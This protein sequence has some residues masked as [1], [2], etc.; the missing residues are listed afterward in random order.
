LLSWTSQQP[1]WAIGFLDQ[2]WWSRFALPK[3]HAWQDKED[4]VR[5]SEQSWQKGDPDA[6]ALACAGV[7]GQRGAVDAPIRDQMLLRVVAG[8]PV[9]GIT[10]QFLAWCCSKLEAQGKT[11]WLLI[12]DNASWHTSKLVRT[13]L[14]EHNQHVK[15]TGKGVRILPLLLPK[16]SPWLNPIEPKWV[17]GKRAVVEPNG[18][19]SAKQLAE[20]I[21]AYYHCSY[22]AHLSLPEKV[23]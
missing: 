15:Q 4:P 17:P 19:L 21:C 7:L 23:S 18:L 2:V 22:E 3:A 8:R 11:G 1:N 20:R 14:R 16:Q 10:T 12:W 9:S 6:K 5:C 13:W